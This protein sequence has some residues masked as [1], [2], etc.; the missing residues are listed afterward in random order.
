MPRGSI[1]EIVR[2]VHDQTISPQQVLSDS[3]QQFR[4]THGWLNALAQPQYEDAQEVCI[5]VD[6]ESS[7]SGVP[8]SIKEC[9]SVQGLQ[10]TLG[11]PSRCGFVD[12]E[13]ASIVQKLKACGVVVVG[14]SNIPQ[15]MYLH[16]KK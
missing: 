10:T 11:I 12:T 13:D 5:N 7:L 15:A 2:A 6:R 16:G 8:V 4:K 9:F 1:G 14:K 3:Y